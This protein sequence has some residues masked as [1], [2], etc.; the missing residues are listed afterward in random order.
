MLKWEL[1]KDHCTLITV[2]GDCIAF[3]TGSRG[4]AL[5]NRQETWSTLLFFVNLEGEK[6]AVRGDKQHLAIFGA[7]RGRR[8]TELSVM[9]AIEKKRPGTFVDKDG[10][11]VDT[12]VA[13]EEWGTQC[14]FLAGGEYPYA[15]GKKGETRRKLATASDCILEYVGQLAFMSGSR[16]ARARADQYM[17]WLLGQ[18]SDAPKG[19]DTV[20]TE[21]R[22]DVTPVE[23]PTSYVGFVTGK[24]GETLREIERKSGTFCFADRDAPATEGFEKLLVFAASESSRNRAVDLIR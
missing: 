6:P 10:R 17:T 3:V 19:R 4:M 22:S 23:I 8:G 9:Q 7:R 12:P 13:G 20:L 18:K 14:R 1:H 11:P 15:L 16:A 24:M 5:R 2:P 21:E